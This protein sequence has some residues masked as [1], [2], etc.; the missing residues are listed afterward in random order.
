MLRSNG[1]SYYLGTLPYLG[2]PVEQIKISDAINMNDIS[3]FEYFA[4]KAKDNPSRGLK[5]PIAALEQTINSKKTTQTDKAQ[6]SLDPQ[7]DLSHRKI[8]GNSL[9][10]I[11]KF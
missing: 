2:F 3:W 8:F 10:E 5:K 1:I 11:Y 7:L 6:D 9:K 4:N